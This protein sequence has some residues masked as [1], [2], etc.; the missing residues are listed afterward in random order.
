[1]SEGGGV[2]EEEIVEYI[3]GL[4]LVDVGIVLICRGHTLIGMISTNVGLGIL[5]NG[6]IRRKHD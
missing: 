5:V 2:Q 6:G 4:V 1:M 3:I